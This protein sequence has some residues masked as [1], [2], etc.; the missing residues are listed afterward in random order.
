[1]GYSGPE[2][3]ARLEG[4]DV[5]DRNAV[6]SGRNSDSSRCL[7]V[8]FVGVW[9]ARDMKG[10][11]SVRMGTGRGESEA[12]AAFSSSSRYISDRCKVSPVGTRTSVG[13][14]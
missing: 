5:R 2:S 13:L 3:R 12:D 1:M 6:S 11:N 7:Y 4:F 10:I 14:G 9:A 8:V